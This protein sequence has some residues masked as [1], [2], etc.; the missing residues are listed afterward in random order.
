V[1][2][3]R[4]DGGGTVALYVWAGGS[5]THDA[6]PDGTYRIVFAT[7]DGWSSRCGRF[8][9]RED[10]S[11]FGTDEVFATERSGGMVYHSEL[12]LTLHNVVGGNARIVDLPLDAF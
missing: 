2:L 3:K 11:G 7:G 1:K 10:V 6:V 8:T 9:A 4:P 5:A 12:R